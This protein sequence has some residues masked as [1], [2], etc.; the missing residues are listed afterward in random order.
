M[1]LLPGISRRT[2]GPASPRNIDRSTILL[3]PIIATSGRLITGVVAIPPK[4][5]SE[6]TVSVD[7][8]S[9]SD[10]PLPVRAASGQPRRQHQ[11]RPRGH[12]GRRYQSPIRHRSALGH[13]RLLRPASSNGVVSLPATTSSPSTSSASSDSPV[14]V[15]AQ[16]IKTSLQPS[17]AAP[18]G[19]AGAARPPVP[20]ASR[21]DGARRAA[22]R[23]VR[24]G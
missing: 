15:L 2:A 21:H 16:M 23:G 11:S 6:V 22:V 5:P 8:D 12:G 3:G 10:L 24:G 20:D 17:T 18:A 7:P 1:P 19:R 9:S 4:G 14:H 13:R